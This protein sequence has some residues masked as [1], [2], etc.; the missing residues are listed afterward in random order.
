MTTVSTLWIPDAAELA[1]DAADVLSPGESQR[2]AA[3]RH[4]RDRRRYVVAHVWLRRLLGS[5]LDLPPRRVPFA[6]DACVRCAGPHG[7]PQLPAATGLHFSLSHAG[8]VAM[9][10]VGRAPVGV[11]VEAVPAG[12]GYV[13]LMGALEPRER[14]AVVA[15]PAAERAAA[16]TQC[17]VRKEAYLKGTAEGLSRE[18]EAVRVGVG[19]RFGD[20]GPEAGA[21]GGW[22]LTDLDAP[23]GYAAAIACQVA[24]EA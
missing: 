16:F 23:P 14:R 18:P 13:E 11:D 5:R 4:D 12:A 1:D 24:A 2:A 8:D 10:A 21:L 20:P 3:F 9:C 7:K 6:A 17:W 22:Q 19:A 15:L